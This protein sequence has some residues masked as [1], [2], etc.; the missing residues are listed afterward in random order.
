MTE[1][2]LECCKMENENLCFENEKLTTFSYNK[3]E[4]GNKK[5]KIKFFA[6]VFGKASR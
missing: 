1:K 3:F 5:P 2:S 6:K 4:E